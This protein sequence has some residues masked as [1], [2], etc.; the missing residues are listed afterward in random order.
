[1]LP[2]ADVKAL[3]SLGAK[4]NRGFLSRGA[5]WRDRVASLTE[6]EMEE[7]K[8]KHLGSMR[9]SLLEV[10]SEGEE[11][12]EK[13]DEEEKIRFAKAAEAM[14]IHED[15]EDEGVNEDD[16]FRIMS[17]LD[18][19][20]SKA[21]VGNEVDHNNKMIVK[22]TCSSKTTAVTAAAAASIL[23]PSTTMT[24]KPA[25]A[26]ASV[27]AALKKDSITVVPV[28][29]T[30]A[31]P[32]PKPKPRQKKLK[33][34]EVSDNFI[35]LN[36]KRKGTAKNRKVKSVKSLARRQAWIEQRQ[37]CDS[38]K[39]SGTN[40]GKR[41]GNR[42]SRPGR[43]VDPLDVC[44]DVLEGFLKVGEKDEV[45][46]SMMARAL[47]EVSQLRSKDIREVR[48]PVLKALA[49]KC[50]HHHQPSRLLRVKKSGPNKGRRFYTCSFPRGEECGFFMWVEDNPVLVAAEIGPPSV[51]SL[52]SLGKEED[53]E[54]TER[55]ME[56]WK[57]RFNKMTIPELKDQAKRRGLALSGTKKVLVARLMDGLEEAVV[58]PGATE[59]K[60]E[61][62]EE[63]EK[64]KED[65]EEG[66]EE[67]DD[68]ASECNSDDEDY[69]LDIIE[70]A[71]EGRP[72][73]VEEDSGDDEGQ[74]D[75]GEEDEEDEDEAE[76][77]DGI[78]GEAV[79]AVQPER[80]RRIQSDNSSNEVEE[81]E[82]MDEGETGT[83]DSDSDDE[84]EKAPAKKK[85]RK[86]PSKAKS[87]PTKSKPGSKLE[88]ADSYPPV[89]RG[90]APLPAPVLG[91]GE[92]F[93]EEMARETLQGIFGYQDFRPGQFWAIQRALAGENSLL[94]LPTGAGKSLCYQ[95]AAACAPVGS[96]VMVVS[97][98]ISLMIDQLARLPPQVPGAC[99]AGNL[100]MRE[101]ARIIRDLR[102]GRLRV[103]FVSPEKLC[104]PSFGRLVGEDVAGR[105]GAAFPPV[106]LV[107][108]DEAHCI[109]Q[110]SHN[111]RPAFL[112]L[113]RNIENLIKP[114]ALLAMT[115]TADA[116]VIGDICARL[117]IS[118]TEGVL[119]QPWRRHNLRL[120]VELLDGDAQLKRQRILDLLSRPPYDRGSVIVY[121]R[122]QR[123]AD[124]LK[125]F[126]V[127]QGQP[128]IA[129]HAGMDLKHRASAQSAWMRRRG[130][131]VGG[132]AR[133]C[134]ATIAFGLGVDKGDVRAVLHYEM[135]KSIENLVQETGRAGRD[136]KEAWCPT[137]LS[138]DDFWRQHS[139][140]HSDGVTALQLRGL[141]GMLSSLAAAA[142][143]TP[144]A[145]NRGGGKEGGKEEWDKEGVQVA[146]DIKNTSIALDIREEVLE[147]AL[148]LMELPPFSMLTLH[149][150]VQDE[151]Q[152]VFRKRQASM[153][154]KSEAVIDTL[155][156]VGT[157][158]ADLFERTSD[159]FGASYGYGSAACSLVRLASAMGPDWKPHDVVKE[160]ARLQTMGELQFT[161]AA[162]PH[163]HLTLLPPPSS[164]TSSSTEDEAAA[165]AAAVSSTPLSL[166]RI[167]EVVAALAERMTAI[168]VASVQKVEQV[169]S[170]LRA[171]AGAPDE[172][173]QEAQTLELIDAYFA[174]KDLPL[175]LNLPMSFAPA[176]PSQVQVVMRRD[177]NILL[178]DPRLVL[179]LQQVVG[180]SRRRGAPTN[181]NLEMELRLYKARLVT[182]VFHGI[183]S[184]RVPLME[185]RESPFWGKHRQYKFEDVESTL[186][187]GEG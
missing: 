27:A 172:E 90:L 107:C 125:E 51:M 161:A 76:D 123:D 136:G 25:V 110:W 122:Q 162:K 4:T 98:L 185:W 177:A 126:L 169:Y 105:G 116:D 113:G 108:I 57:A 118:P 132:H 20:G 151:F 41:G 134:V 68:E 128:A 87:P 66:S 1:M 120:R 137:L 92:M 52:P 35:A 3:T 121:V 159:T 8:E 64:E 140:A 117:R 69:E 29:V 157:P 147:T 53:A 165:E 186:S 23:P 22:A 61:Q 184:P 164:T 145:Q 24:K 58:A 180:R 170:V 12:E 183:G 11:E 173:G 106:S 50:A 47:E 187:V 42:M 19:A 34:G 7:G 181:V 182:R 54:W 5:A 10:K 84:E 138:Q 45:K 142:K 56:G 154:R 33:P 70:A 144:K 160:L 18:E 104:S 48:D 67:G 14:E 141:L 31:L 103:L 65:V 6:A 32:L 163:F 55:Q 94:M 44:L 152:V 97:P 143:A 148:V 89:M 17:D 166:H 115:A 168:E 39:G 124:V 88:K 36:L 176:I 96:L 78:A 139:L 63:E 62:E 146:V 43:A 156:D 86:A 135:P 133:V 99:L 175:P 131:R 49:P 13:E 93:T 21:S 119:L 129:Y 80:K 178:L 85:S 28:E 150:T 37:E 153:L 38:N 167:G 73:E 101:L 75:E 72:E 130:T 2:T 79:A 74:K 102:S 91:S 149:G 158:S 60:K 112:R 179:L 40:G 30:V 71:L 46:E 83:S 9:L 82:A 81:K 95:M 127:S 26:A 174:K 109:S 16:A 59:I 114:R 100:S 171:A 111:F 155:L 77:E 15:E